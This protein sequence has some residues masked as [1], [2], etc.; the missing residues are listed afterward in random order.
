VDLKTIHNWVKQGHIDGR[1]TPG[2]HL[3][4]DRRQVVRFLRDYDYPIPSEVAGPEPRVLLDS[5]RGADWRDVRLLLGRDGVRLSTGLF[6]TT[7]ALS[8]QID[9]VVVFDLDCRDL[10]HLAQLLQALRG[11]PALRSLWAVGV[12]RSAPARRRFLGAGGDAALPGGCATELD[13]LLCWLVGRERVAPA[14]AE[15]SPAAPSAS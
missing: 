13:L 7:L 6:E 2:G 11:W 10:D 8:E 15:L 4:F 9:E 12:G 1:R 5:L 3:R 14:L